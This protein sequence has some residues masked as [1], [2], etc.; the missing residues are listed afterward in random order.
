MKRNLLAGLLALTALSGC[1][2]TGGRAPATSAPA[3]APVVAAVPANAV[4][5]Q[6]PNIAPAM[7]VVR[8]E[9]TT[10][11]LLGTFHALDGRSEWFNDE[12]K[13]AFDASSELVLEIQLPADA[14]QMQ[15]QLV[16]LIQR[17]A[18]DPEGRKLSSVLTAAEYSKLVELLAPAGLPAAAID[19]LEPWFVSLQVLNVIAARIQLDPAYGPE[20]ILTDAATARGMRIGALET[21]ESQFAIFDGTPRAEQIEGLKKIL[22]DPEASMRTLQPMLEAWSRGDAER[23]AAITAEGFGEDRDGYDRLFTNRNALWARWID[24]RM[25]RPGTVFIAVGAGHLAGRG[26][27][28]EQLGRL[29]IQSARVPAR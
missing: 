16:P 6:K 26:S 23:I 29:G 25:D 19:I 14:T 9:D 13:E 10:I 3:P 4:P 17:L 7:W 18:I 8:D 12:V 24:D 22:E 21:I 2:A 1:A 11:Y 5:A 27:V 15:A 28:Q 20:R